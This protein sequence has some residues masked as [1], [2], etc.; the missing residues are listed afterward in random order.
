MS[1]HRLS[2]V[3]LINWGTFDGGR[4]FDVPRRGLLLTGPSGAG[5]SSILDA[6]GTLL[7]R[8]RKQKFNAAAQGTETGDRER[9]L[10]TYVL[11]AY[12]R[13]T[14]AATGEVGTAYL[15]SG[16][17]WSGVAL[18]FDDARGQCT[19]LIR[20]FHL[21][22]GTTNPADLRSMFIMAT[23]SVDL[24]TLA[25]Y[26]R[27]G[28][29]NRRVQRDFPDWV[30]AS[31]DSYTSFATKFRR[32]LG[33][34]TE[35]AQLLLHKTQSAKNLTNLDSLFRDFMLEEPDTFELADETVRQFEEL[36]Q[37][38][39][40]VVDARRQVNALMPL[41]DLD[42]QYRSGQ[43]SL[44]G[45][46]EEQEHLACWLTARDL[47]S[48]QAELV[49]TQPRL[50]SLDGHVVE[51]ENEVSAA[52]RAR[53]EAQRALDGSAGAQLGTLE[54]LIESLRS[55]RSS[56]ERKSDDL[57]A[58]ADFAGLEWPGT[59]EAVA[60]FSTLL[61]EAGAALEAEQ[62]DRQQATWAALDRHRE[63]KATVSDLESALA[64]LRKHGSNLDPRLLDARADLAARL[65]VADSSLPFVGE[66]IEVRP[67]EAPWA[68]AIER[69]LGSFA[70]TLLVPQPHYVAAAEYLDATFLGVRL[71]YE[72]VVPLP[73]SHEQLI[74]G[75][76]SLARK[77]ALAE[78]AYQSWVADRLTRR[79][80]YVCVEYPRD[81]SRHDRAVTRA[82]QVKHSSTR[83]E[84]DDRRRVDDRS[85]WVLGFSTEAKEAELSRRVDEARQDFE[86]ATRAAEEARRHE[87][88]LQPRRNALGQLEG[89]DWAELDASLVSKQLASNEYRLAQLR[90]DNT[91]IPQLEA[92]L[93]AARARLSDAENARRDLV[94]TRDALA[95]KL[96]QI[97]DRISELEGELAASPPVPPVVAEQLD[98]RAAELTVRPARLESELRKELSD[99]LREA[100]RQQAAV[101][102]RIARQQRVYTTQWPAQGADWADTVDYLPEFLER[103]DALEHDGLPQFEQRFFELLQQQA[104]N[105]ISQLKQLIQGARRETRTRVHEVN[106]SLLL[107]EFSAGAFL[108]IDVKERAPD[109]VDEFLRALN[110]ITSGSFYDLGADDT[111]EERAAAEER[112]AVMQD[113]LTKLG[114]SDPAH[115]AW[116]ERCLDTRQHVQF[117]ARV[118]DADNVQL[119]VYTGSGGRSGGERQKLVTFCLAAALRYQLAPPGQA[120][121][122]FGLVVI[123]E[124]FDKADHEF[125]QAGLEVFRR[126][127]FQLLLATPMKMLQTIDD[128]VGGVVMVTNGSG[129]HS[130]VLQ[131]PFV[132]DVDASADLDPGLAQ[133][134]LL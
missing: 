126:F 19:T 124:A 81:L 21:R 55:R 123:D 66:L 80:D 44:G 119:D 36:S 64:A 77:V 82:G 96:S 89:I 62:S 110:S 30:C 94:S 120:E 75:V 67:D 11:G 100:E 59:P 103:L 71:V 76:E 125:T 93:T 107:T 73:D 72:R 49:Q 4:A 39:N 23:E 69:V 132:D 56:I 108:Q 46:T 22:A 85:R 9:N 133:E 83:H 41:R 25:P 28:I 17:V 84:K 128:Y 68:G 131:L 102:N 31:A 115:R 79:F 97:E 127:G 109:G 51:A 91:E 48:E 27:D 43:A 18:T 90:R 10:V 37:A 118:V 113:L 60:R 12:K 104:R 129:R 29:E 54:E 20:L 50:A 47:A 92:S 78:G 122:T 134:A 52:E 7:V 58:A 8:P 95:S 112:F 26:A 5:K 14:D 6:M 106:K 88:D 111:G 33:L 87:F 114:S 116:R 13:E 117:Q 57:A 121:P 130:Q 86:D 24:G 38:H 105:N 3:Q 101:A 32:R 74:V 63:A 2:R 34:G 99:R 42:A 70:R 61:A 65:G 40:A 53:V 16:P 98:A 1:Q 15:R 35:Q 45:L